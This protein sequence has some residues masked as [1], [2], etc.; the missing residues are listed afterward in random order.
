MTLSYETDRS[1]VRPS[2]AELAEGIPT[3]QSSADLEAALQEAIIASRKLG[4]GAVR[5]VRASEPG[6]HDRPD[7][8]GI[9]GNAP[10]PADFLSPYNA[11]IVLGSD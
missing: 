9:T 11:R 3:E 4:E 6:F 2:D 7:E 10:I 5:F 8:L 1:L